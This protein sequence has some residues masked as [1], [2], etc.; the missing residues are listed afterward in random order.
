VKV[1]YYSPLPPEASGIADYSELLLPALRRR[2]DVAVV[3]RGRA[4]PPR[5]VDVSVYQVGNS[6]DAHGWILDALRRRPGLVVLH[7]VV[8]HHLV[9]GVTLARGHAEPYLD[10]MHAEAGVVGRLLAHGVIDGV[11]P[12]LW[13]TRAEDFPLTGVALAHAQ[14]VVVHS[15][16][17]EQWVRRAGYAGRLWRIPHPAWRPPPVERDPELPAGRSPVIGCFGH[18]TPSKRLPKLFAAF[19][20]LRERFPGALLVLAGAASERGMEI[21]GWLAEAGL[22]RDRDVRVLGYVPEQRLWS[23]LASSDVVVA[24]RW[25]SMGETSGTAVRALA[26]GRPLVVT[27]CGWFG[28]LPDDVAVKVPAGADEP[29]RLSEALLEL[30][31]DDALRGRMGAAARAHAE[32]EHDLERVADLYLAAIEE[33]AGGDAVQRELLTEIAVAAQAVG[34]DA[35]DPEL[36]RVA[37]H[38]RGVGLGD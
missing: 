33:A 28:E 14:G 12:P 31:G 9:A 3:P 37:G 26:V 6:P 4:R 10:A 34:V 15:A 17:A 25:P 29:R 2:L 8:L 19:A 11:V 18:L 5:G 23:L 30:A 21:D 35:F 16:H 24:L 36:R 32:R 22:E 20:A 38:V 1:A 7:D 13:E 27:D